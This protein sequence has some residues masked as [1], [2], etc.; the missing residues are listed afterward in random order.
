M[1]EENTNKKQQRDDCRASAA[2]S[3]K[4]IFNK[5]SEDEVYAMPDCI[6]EAWEAGKDIINGI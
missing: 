1:K 4:D 5:F 3:C 6:Q 2:E